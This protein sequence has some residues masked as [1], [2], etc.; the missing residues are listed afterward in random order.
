MKKAFVTGAGIR[1]GRAI[2]LA[3]ARSGWDLILH[4]NASLGPLEDVAAEARAL[5]SQVDRRLGDLADSEVV[6][7]LAASIR[8]D[9]PAL[10]LVVHNAAIFEQVPFER[11]DRERWR[12]MQAIN[13]EAPFFLTESGA[14]RPRESQAHS[15]VSMAGLA[16]LT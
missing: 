3:L 4:A 2:A 12:R 6:E 11:I 15:A 16:M 1:V 13:L 8:A 9:H 5:G 10:D 14:D 7:R